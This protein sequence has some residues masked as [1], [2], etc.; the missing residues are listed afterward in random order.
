MTLN[1]PVYVEA[2]QALAQRLVKEGGATTESRARFGF[3]VCLTRPPSEAEVIRLVELFDKARQ[4]YA[5]KPKE[6]QSMA[7]DPLGPLPAGMDPIEVAAW[8][9]VSN[10]LLNLDEMFAKR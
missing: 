9:V 1:D 7:T 6:A 3:R 2:A 5:A 8:T 10:V 4:D